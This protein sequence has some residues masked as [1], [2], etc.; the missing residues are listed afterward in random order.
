MAIPNSQ[1][2]N[3]PNL[4]CD[5]Y[6]AWKGFS[7]LSNEIRHIHFVMIAICILILA[8][9]SKKFISLF[10][11]IAFGVAALIRVIYFAQGHATLT[12]LAWAL[13]LAILS[14]GILFKLK[15]DKNN[16]PWVKEANRKKE[17]LESAEEAKRMEIEIDERKRELNKKA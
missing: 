6:I 17:H 2:L 3:F 12:Y 1:A 10:A 5:Y 15:R 9:S 4:T 7:C 8:N 14:I 11:C 16:H 13:L